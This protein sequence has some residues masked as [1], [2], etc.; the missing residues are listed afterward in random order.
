[1]KNQSTTAEIAAAIYIVNRH[2]KSALDRRHLYTLKRKTIDKLLHER[3]AEKIGLHFSNNP[4]LKNQ[5]STLLIKVDRY[6]FH[7]L[8]S[9]EDVEK[10]PHLGSLDD[11][12]RNPQT[13]MSLS[14]AKRILYRYL[15]WRHV[16]K[17]RKQHHSSYEFLKSLDHLDWP[18]ENKY[19]RKT[20]RSLEN[21][22]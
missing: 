8:P 12:Y 19:N 11:T 22:R 16:K 13:R 17:K 21:K 5:H 6:Y 1:M 14:E 10:L 4:R 18:K 9:K 7:I 3:K 20:F 2:A 15:N